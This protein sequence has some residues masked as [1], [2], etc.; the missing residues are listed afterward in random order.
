MYKLFLCLRYLFRKPL[1]YAGMVS[2]ALCVAMMLI[3]VSVMNGFLDKIEEAAKGLFG[4]IVVDSGSQHGIPR[5]DE[6]I[7]AVTAEVG[8]VK[9]GSPFILSYGVLRVPQDPN[10]RQFVQIAGVRLPERVDVSDF[11]KGL[12]VQAGVERPTFDPDPKL[13]SDRLEEK[14]RETQAILDRE[15]KSE[16]GGTES[17][18]REDLVDRLGDVIRQMRRIR[19][20]LD[21]I[22]ARRPEMRELVSRL[23]KLKEQRARGAPDPSDQTR[24]LDEQIAAAED[25]LQ[26]LVNE[27]R[28]LPPDY[29][30]VLGLGI[31]GLTIRT[32]DGEVVR[33]LLP[34]DRVALYIFPG[35]RFT[36]S[37]MTPNRK[38]FTVIDDCRTDVST[39]DSMFVYVPFSTLQKLNNM[40]QPNRCSQIHFKIAKNLQSERDLKRIAG[41]IQEV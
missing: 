14:I 18:S 30:L 38:L 26:K 19:A 33:L 7:Q 13:I 17:I 27:I 24:K 4:D 39:I 10:Y 28:Y 9:A 2:V 29:R 8:G 34:T 11:G 32:R 25:Q 21:G 37:D 36:A 35:G 15:G 6:I 16:K 22:A 12:F 23:A 40:D 31:Q 1:A 20:N 41:Q 3:V 5:Y